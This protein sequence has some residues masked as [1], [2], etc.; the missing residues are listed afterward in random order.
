MQ[1]TLQPRISWA[2]SEFIIDE[3][4]GAATL[5]LNRESNATDSVTYNTSNGAAT[6]PADYTTS[7]GTVTWPNGDLAAKTITIPIVADALVEGTQSFTVTLSAPTG[8]SVIVNTA[9]RP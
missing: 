7:T 2:A 1:V 8:G 3:Q 4:G 9:R 5:T 6:A